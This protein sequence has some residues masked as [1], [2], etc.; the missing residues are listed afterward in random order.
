MVLL[1]TISSGN[2]FIDDQLN[3]PLDR[4]HPFIRFFHITQRFSAHPLRVFMKS[5]C[6]FKL[7]LSHWT[8]FYGTVLKLCVFIQTTF[9]K[10]TSGQDHECNL[11]NHPA[12]AGECSQ[13]GG[14]SDRI[15]DYQKMVVM[16]KSVSLH[17]SVK[18]LWLQSFIIF[19]STNKTK[20]K[21]Q[22]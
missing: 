9:F 7:D 1:R 20:I 11:W 2:C 22:I 21:V 17:Y 18:V 19:S 15:S 3:L 4:G 16:L 10:E 6:N 8:V 12:A 14:K 5:L 13:W